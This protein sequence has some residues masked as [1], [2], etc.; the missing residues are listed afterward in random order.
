MTWTFLNPIRFT[1]KYAPA[2]ESQSL[3][4]RPRFIPTVQN[5]WLKV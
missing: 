4:I 2:D 1:L 5:D 3:S